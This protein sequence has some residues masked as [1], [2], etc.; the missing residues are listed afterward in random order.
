MRLG[1]A[2]NFVCAAAFA[3]S[4]PGN[5][6]AQQAPQPAPE[7]GTASRGLRTIGAA[8]FQPI[9]S[10]T[11]WAYNAVTWQKYRTGGQLYFD[12]A[13]TDLP[14]GALITGLELEACDT[15]PT[16]GVHV[17]LSRHSSPSGPGYTVGSTVDTGGPFVPGCA[18]T[19]SST[20]LEA[21]GEIV[22]NFNWVYRLRVTLNATD[23]STSLGAVRVFYRLRVSP[24]PAVATFNDVPT[25]HPFFQFVEALAASGIT[26]GCGGGNFCPDAP[27]TRKQMAAFLSIALGLHFPY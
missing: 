27:L 21:D 26:A 16:L 9:Q 14:S 20:N 15:N 13:L 19:G 22:D 18:F 12:A 4:M 1:R 3:A 5:L 23:D 11:T 8:A 7:W 25:S 17:S 24:S 6:A 2:S 10:D